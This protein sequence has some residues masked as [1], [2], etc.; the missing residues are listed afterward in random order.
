MGNWTGH[1]KCER[2]GG[3][4]E[5]WCGVVLNVSLCRVVLCCADVSFRC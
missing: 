3:E 1:T 4:K 2:V 5:G